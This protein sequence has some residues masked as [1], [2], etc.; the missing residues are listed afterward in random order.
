MAQE[1]RYPS[2]EPGNQAHPYHNQ[3]PQQPMPPENPPPLPH[4]P[5]ALMHE[6]AGDANNVPQGF[7][8]VQSFN[9][10]EPSTP[11][12]M[13]QQGLDA[14][15]G[16]NTDPSAKKKSKVSRACDECR[17]KKVRKHTLPRTRLSIDE[18]RCDVMPKLISL[19]YNARTADEP[20]RS[21]NS[22]DSPRSEVQAKGMSPLNSE[23]SHLLIDYSYIKELAE[24]V[25]RLEYP[26]APQPEMQ[27]QGIASHDAPTYSPHMPYNTPI[28]ARKRTHSMADGAPE[29]MQAADQLQ[30]HARSAPPPPSMAVMQ[31]PVYELPPQSGTAI[32]GIAQTVLDAYVRPPRPREFD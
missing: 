32:F 2:P 29:Y 21:V 23:R 19:A 6:S 14:D 9:P 5:T 17:R 3:Q 1:N 28:Q 12:Q 18:I 11:Q 24:R 25:S 13:A 15:R 8:Y 4:A 31:A 16:Q 26:G 20:T 30:Y 10:N 22:V 7:Q 27:Y